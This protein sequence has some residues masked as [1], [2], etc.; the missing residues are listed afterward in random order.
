LSNEPERVLAP[1]LLLLLLTCVFTTAGASAQ[2]VTQAD[3]DAIE[4]DLGNMGDCEARD[5]LLAM[6]M[7]G[8]A[9]RCFPRDSRLANP[10]VGDDWSRECLGRAVE[11]A[12]EILG[13]PDHRDRARALFIAGKASIALRRPQAGA[14][15]LQRYL[16]DFP[17]DEEVSLVH[18]TLAEKAW[19]DRAWEDAAA[20]YEAASVGLTDDENAALR[21][22]LG[23]SR[24]NAGDPVA[25]ATTLARLLSAGETLDGDVRATVR[26]D[27]TAMLVEVADPATTIA[28][29][30][31]GLGAEAPDL[32]EA[33][34]GELMTDERLG[35][36]G[37]TFAA[38]VAA[39]PSRDRAATWQVGCVDAAMARQDAP[40]AV[41]SLTVLMRDY[42]ARSKY[43][44]T[45]DRWSGREREALKVEETS[46]SAAARLHQQ[47]REGYGPPAADVESLYRLYLQDFPRASKVPEVRLAL[48]S[49]LQEQDRR[50]DAIDELLGVV[51][52][53]S[54]REIGARAARL[55]T[56]LIAQGLAEG[57]ETSAHEDRVLQL[58]TLFRAGYARHTDGVGYALQAGRIFL[59]REQH[60]DA[61]TVLMEA[62][63]RLPASVD[64]GA[65]VALA[66]ETPLQ[67]EDWN[68][69]AALADEV[70][71]ADRL[72]AAHPE[73]GDVA[74]RTRATA[75]FNQAVALWEG[76][77]PAV[78]APLF[79]QVATDDPE[80]GQAPGA[81]LNAASCLAEAGDAGRA[82]MLLRRVY[83]RYPDS[84]V[85][86]MA[87]EQEAY[88]RWEKE[89][90][91]GAAS[92]YLRLA[93]TFPDSER[94]PFAL[95]TAAAL[96]DQEGLF[97]EAIDA[98]STLVKKYP[99]APEAAEAHP[100]LTEL[101]AGE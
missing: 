34:A 71:A 17:D 28:L 65:C 97:D 51:S 7:E 101:E 6:L 13:K 38:M 1:F 90:Y 8:L 75:R 26:R 67:A 59:Q 80:G 22:R 31:T 92:V 54:G 60:E 88:L 58:A 62:A 14:D 57:V 9:E 2:D 20:H 48:A 33:V 81:L 55:A 12:D 99:A 42:G 61:R 23:W 40:A 4:R 21:Y 30:E 78:A 27:L 63:T 93:D 91:E 83:T 76:G 69:A 74:R 87:I 66:L 39:W 32:A 77:D 41:E 70:L 96:Y 84:E 73:L 86:D 44:M 29:A 85:A 82:P 52:D 68:G 19:S 50:L 25:G 24:Y 35:L 64:A 53:E 100:R 45:V 72:V 56:D 36:A 10:V 98:Y 5:N 46:R 37:A 18:Y 47:L 15:Y 95:Y 3:I 11:V 16:E 43:A 49:L 94:A 89:D 79:E